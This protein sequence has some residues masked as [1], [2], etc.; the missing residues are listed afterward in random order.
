M[1]VEVATTS[2][3]VQCE[4]SFSEVVAFVSELACGH[5]AALLITREHQDQVAIR[6]K[7]LFLQS[8]KCRS[9][10]RHA[11]LVVDCAACIEIVVI[12][13]QLERRSLPVV[14]IRLDNVHMP[15]KQNRRLTGR[16]VTA[17]AGDQ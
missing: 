14:G 12:L 15:E 1:F 7:A 8:N 6:Y 2:I 9:K 17:I 16:S 10:L 5:H 13:G 4:F 11:E 3:R